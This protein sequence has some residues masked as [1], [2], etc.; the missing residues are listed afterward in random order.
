MPKF[1]IPH[2][3]SGH[4]GS[5][6][7]DGSPYDVPPKQEPKSRPPQGL[8]D[9]VPFYGVLPTCSGPYS[10]SKP[11]LRLRIVADKKLGWLYVSRGPSCAPS[12]FLP[13]HQKRSAHTSA[14]DRPDVRILPSCVWYWSGKRSF[15]ARRLVEG[16][17]APTSQIRRFKGVRG[18]CGN[19]RLAYHL[20]VL[21]DDLV[22]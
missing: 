12:D 3:I 14:G 21:H 5:G 16:N 10:V 20:P 6:Q 17:L 22:H 11:F 1:G 7:S 8:R 15:R 9:K 13:H 2:W 19:A 4:Q 18:F